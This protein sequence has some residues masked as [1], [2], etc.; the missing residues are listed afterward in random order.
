LYFHLAVIAQRVLY[1]IL[2]TKQA[3]GNTH[4]KHHQPGDETEPAM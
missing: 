2:E 1:L 4:N 3:T